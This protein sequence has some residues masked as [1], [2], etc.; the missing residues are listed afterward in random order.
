MK[1]VY[2]IQISTDERST[3]MLR[4]AG[5]IAL[6]ESEVNAN[7]V[8]QKVGWYGSD[9]TVVPVRIYSTLNERQEVLRRDHLAAIKK[10]LTQEELDALTEEL[11]K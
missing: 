1:T 8:A 4:D 7:V 10:K 11:R 6:F 9:G 2:G 5:E 3:G